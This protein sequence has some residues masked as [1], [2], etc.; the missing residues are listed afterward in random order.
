MKEKLIRDKIPTQ[1]LLEGRALKIRKAS[2]DELKDLFVAK[3]VEEANEV[4]TAKDF[5]QLIEELADLQQVLEDFQSSL[6]IGGY[7]GR[8]KQDKK[9]T[10]GGF[11]DFIVLIQEDKNE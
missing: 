4:Q 10:R 1:A 7:V 11:E 9:E 5:E 6:R 8:I 2:Q 3:I